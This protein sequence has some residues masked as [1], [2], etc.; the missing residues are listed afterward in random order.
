[1]QTERTRPAAV[2]LCIAAGVI[3]L[4]GCA[5]GSAAAPSAT[6]PGA[7]L[8]KEAKVP[9]DK[10]PYLFFSTKDLPAIRERVKRHP[11]SFFWARLQERTDPDGLDLGLL[12]SI[13]GVPRFR[14]QMQAEHMSRCA[15]YGLLTGSEKH[16]AKAKQALLAIV[17]NWT[18]K[19]GRYGPQVGHLL[20][21]SAIAYDWLYNHLTAEER[22]KV[23]TFL[24]EAAK[25]AYEAGKTKQ[26][27]NWWYAGRAGRQ[28]S[29]QPLMY[30]G[31]GL[32][33]LVL[34]D[35]HPEAKVWAQVATGVMKEVMEENFDADGGGYEAYTTYI[36]HATFVSIYPMMEAVR[37]VT[38]EDLFHHADDVLYK[39]TAFTAYMFRPLRGE[40]LSY[41]A[42]GGRPNVVGL[43]LLK[44]A[45]EYDD[46]L[47]AWYLETLI[48][49]GWKSTDAHLLWGALWARKVAPENPDTSPRLSEAYA[50][51]NSTG[52]G[53][54]N[55]GTGHVFLR[56]GFADKDG[57]QLGLKAGLDGLGH[58]GPDKGG[59]MLNAYGERFLQREIWKRGRKSDGHNFVMIDGEHQRIASQPSVR[60]AAVDTLQSHKG[61]DYVKLDLTQAYREHQKNKD[62]RKV[63]RHVVFV[64]TTRKTGYFVVIDDVQKDDQPHAYS[65]AFY[66]D[67]RNVK[68][69]E[70]KDNRIVI[71]GEKAS[72]HIAAVYPPKM[73]A[74]EED[75][76]GR[77][78]T[79]MTYAPKVSRFVLV[80]VLYP[81]K[82]GDAPPAFAPVDEGGRAGVEVSGTK[83]VYDKSTGKVTVSGKLSDVVA[84]GGKPGE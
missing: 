18:P 84:R 24:A 66:Y 63:H 81:V 57:I 1:M 17:T 2:A 46:G 30:S 20:Q 22:T 13:G 16:L 65:H 49:E 55:Y 75:R 39:S 6:Q 27:D 9:T 54:W 3:V 28:M 53:K 77:A 83:I 42:V 76:D 45:A 47:A 61:Y 15:F 33:G 71:A 10:H 40:M 8:A 25:N 29:H 67:P 73:Q 69:R 41:G 68:V 56:T 59:Y 4:F 19:P 36:L 48:K 62:T 31:I 52:K 38:G 82:S 50:Y 35:K 70:A 7:R 43:Q 11:A 32:I 58:G 74:T 60:I 37:R 12:R 26:Q 44:N 64:R 21:Y 72:L 79:L 14:Q 34:Y 5:A 78:Y 80:T 51:T 23:E